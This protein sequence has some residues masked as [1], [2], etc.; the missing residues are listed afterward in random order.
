MGKKIDK[1]RRGADKLPFP[2]QVIT[3]PESLRERLEHCSSDDR[4]KI[5]AYLTSVFKSA[6]VARML[7]MT[8]RQVYYSAEKHSD[9]TEYSKL[10]RASALVE[11][12]HKKAFGLLESFDPEEVPH[13]KRAQ[14][15]KYLIEAADTASLMTN[16][17]PEEDKS[18]VTREL[19]F[20]VTDKMTRRSYEDKG[21]C[22]EA[23][24]EEGYSEE[25]EEGRQE[26][27][28]L[29]EAREPVSITIPSAS[30]RVNQQGEE[31][32]QAGVRR[33]DSCSTKHEATQGIGSSD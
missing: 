33:H 15:I 27:G 16:I 9:I 14:A 32:E 30:V 4:M 29:P 13:E 12:C 23:E 22:I 20:K 28:E 10:A 7:G 18:E 8:D 31:I 24:A 5:A 25:R 17:K 6:E 2:V 1:N 3:D 11:T 21:S 19:I 26:G